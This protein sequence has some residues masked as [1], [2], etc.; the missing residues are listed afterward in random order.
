MPLLFS[1]F[2]A[3]SPMPPQMR[4]VTPLSASRVARLPWEYSPESRI[5]E[6]TL[7]PSTVNTLNWR[8]LPKCWKT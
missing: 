7:L 6:V 5:S 4:V 2:L 3:P 1:M 8:V